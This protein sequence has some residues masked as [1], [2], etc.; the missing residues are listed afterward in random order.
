MA[1]ELCCVIEDEITSWPNGV[2]RDVDDKIMKLTSINHASVVFFCRKQVRR[3]CY[4]I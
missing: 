4:A 1:L 2:R 3:S